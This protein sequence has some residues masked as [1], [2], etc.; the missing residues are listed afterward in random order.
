MQMLLLLMFNIQENR[1]CTPTLHNHAPLGS[2][3]SHT[4][5]Y[6]GYSEHITETVHFSSLSQPNNC[7][8]SLVHWVTSQ[9]FS[10][11]FSS[12]GCEDFLQETHLETRKYSNTLHFCLVRD[13]SMDE[14]QK[15][16]NVKAQQN[17]YRRT[18]NIMNIMEG[19]MKMDER[20]KHMGKI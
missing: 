1:S 4:I 20:G 9:H 14:S 3:R 5:V 19:W 2:I 16:M 8:K 6:Y 11:E 18:S 15:W 13:Q 7:G 10:V 12:Q 17:T